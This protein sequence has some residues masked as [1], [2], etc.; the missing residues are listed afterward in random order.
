M[1]MAG[2]A[3]LCTLATLVLLLQPQPELLGLH[4]QLAACSAVAAGVFFWFSRPSVPVSMP[5]S[6]LVAALV[7]IAL[8]VTLAWQLGTGLRTIVLGIVPLLMGLALL[9]A[10][11][12]RALLV[13]AAGAVGVA[14]LAWRDHAAGPEAAA[15]ALGRLTLSSAV[16]AHVVMLLGGLVFGVVARTLVQRWRQLADER[17]RQ[18]RELLASA[19]DRYLELDAELRFA[20]PTV[21][22]PSAAGPVPSS[23]IGR[24]PWDVPGLVFDP[25]EARRHEEDLRARRPFEIEVE[26]RAD[27]R[28]PPQRLAISG[29]PRYSTQGQFLGYWCAGRDISAQQQQRDATAQAA[30]EAEAASRAKSSFLANMSHEVRTPLNGILGLARLARQH[31][32]E[33]E[34]LVGYLDLISS[35]ATALHATL[36]DVLD[37]SRAEASQLNLTPQR[38]DL[39]ALLGDL[40]RVHVAL[41][42]ARGLQCTL[43][44]DP[45]LPQH[46]RTD[47]GRLR[48]ILTNFL[49][50]AL[51]FTSQGRIAIEVRALGDGRWRFAVQDSGP[52]IAA[53][54]L[55]RLFMPF[56]QLDDSAQRLHDGSGLGLSIC[57]QLALAMG[58]DVGVS[59]EPGHGSRFWADLPLLPDHSA[60][61][62]RA[63]AAVDGPALAGMRALVVEDNPVNML[64]T[65]ALL[66]DWGLDV[67]QA[68]DG[69]AALACVADEFDAGRHFDVVLMDLQMPGLDGVATTRALRAAGVHTPVVALTATVFDDARAQTLAAG[70]VEVLC[71]PI[72]APLLKALLAGLRRAD[73]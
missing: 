54:H 62:P 26:S 46:V 33:R 22:V 13:C 7:G 70:F 52:G 37:L 56:S 41:C 30:A 34:R 67:A 21:D 10:W 55:P 2:G 6:V 49:H 8:V 58:G 57:R 35:S 44:L 65:V 38:V 71:K 72:D 60:P 40:H 45:G 64:I 31:V 29:R 27:P 5:D 17:E 14:L 68:A 18:F 23:F 32:D 1:F 9:L 19:A 11:G 28:R 73:S 36:S 66:E 61:L 53:A 43:S 69:R 25:G 47:G 4:R 59:S 12:W 63:A 3:V 15:L 51:K 42:Q 16:W 50:N 39:P 48:Q 24:H 20:H